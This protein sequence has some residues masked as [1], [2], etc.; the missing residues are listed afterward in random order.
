MLNDFEWVEK[1]LLPFRDMRFSPMQHIWTDV[2]LPYAVCPFVGFLYMFGCLLLT[3]KSK[4]LT[5][6]ARV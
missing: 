5:I 6:V 3:E 1:S 2:S 4:K